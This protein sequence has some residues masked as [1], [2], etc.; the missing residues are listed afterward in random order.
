MAGRAFLD[1]NILVHLF[2]GGEPAKR[3]VAAGVYRGFDQDDVVLSTQ[4][5]EEFYN[6]VTRKLR[7][8]LPAEEAVAQVVRFSGHE[9]VLLDV[10]IL[11]RAAARSESARISFWDGLIVEA[12][13]S[14][15]CTR[16]LTEDLQHGRVFD[17]LVV[18]NPFS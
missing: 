12:A 6:T 11:L 13:L 1:T 5:L 8:P 18:E 4:V 3:A 17:G 16:L 2:D 14:A 9:V 7:P 15:G 10:P